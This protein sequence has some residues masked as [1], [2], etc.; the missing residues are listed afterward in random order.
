M[1]TGGDE[2]EWQEW[3]GSLKEAGEGVRSVVAA[4]H[5][6]GCMVAWLSDGH[7]IT[8][9][10]TQEGGEK[11][12]QEEEEEEVKGSGGG[13][14]GMAVFEVGRDANNITHTMTTLIP[15]IRKV[16]HSSWCLAVAVVSR[17]SSFLASFGEVWSR[18][19][20]G[21]A[22][23][24]VVMVVTQMPPSALLTLLTSHWT[25][26]MMDTLVIN[27]KATGSEGLGVYCHL[28]YTRRGPRV[29]NVATWTPADGLVLKT[30]S[31]ILDKFSNFYGAKVNVTALPFP[32]YWLETNDEYSGTDYL[33]LATVA[34]ALN[35]TIRVIP[36]TDWGEVT[37]LVQQRQSFMATI[38]YAVLPDR[39]HQYDF[40]YPYE[41]ATP[42]FCMTKP[43]LSP[44]YLS[45][46]YPLSH[47]VWGC[48][49]A[50]IVFVPCVWL[51]LQCLWQQGKL[52]GGVNGGGEMTLEVLRTL[53]G[54]NLTRNSGSGWVRGWW[55]RVLLGAWLV[56]ALVLGVAYRTNLTAALT[57][58]QYPPR[59][60][61]LEQLVGV[62]KKVTMPPYGAQFKD[63]YSKSDSIVFKAL[64]QRMDFVKTAVEGVSQASN[65]QAHIQVRRYLELVVAELFTETDG[66]T[67]L[68][69]G[70]ENVIPGLSA[71][72]IPHQAPYKTHLD[73]SVRAV[74]EAGLYEKWSEDVM[75]EARE[76][77]RKRRQKELQKEK[78]QKEKDGQQVVR[79]Q[80]DTTTGIALTVSH[81]Q[82]PL[83][84]LLL[85]LG[86]GTLSFLV[87]VLYYRCVGVSLG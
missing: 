53:L 20:G 80:R 3:Q 56:F 60:E 82:G 22:G 52:Y 66:S 29:K 17:R 8:S 37:G 73:R 48:V 13:V 76:Q 86:A 1:C 78:E 51:V 49:L 69:L 50:I 63:F 14:L 57:I 19:R 42:T 83:L 18:G 68:Y 4:A 44:Q 35:F 5:Q 87:E 11:A 58:P 85:G 33:L 55:V 24:S 81:L 41:Y 61:T 27:Y 38:I 67:K 74:L 16:G 72:P 25:F 77:G 40:S 79:Q 23:L 12:G 9:L 70:R 15:H 75:T 39:L 10:L 62:V 6:T 2:S 59:P 47:G 64:A 84:L 7:S 54:Q 45:L 31:L 26:T 46:Y 36:T 34:Q 21:T 32:P 71:W 43:V 30:S 65:K 28:P